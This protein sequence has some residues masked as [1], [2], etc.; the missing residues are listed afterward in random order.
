MI[1]YIKI[2]KI[3]NSYKMQ[4][5]TTIPDSTIITLLVKKSTETGETYLERKIEWQYVK[6]CETIRNQPIIDA[7]IPL[8]FDDIPDIEMTFFDIL[9]EFV[10]HYHSDTWVPIFTPPPENVE[11]KIRRQS[12]AMTQWELDKWVPMSLLELHKLTL[13]ANYLE[14]NDFVA[15]ICLEIS[16]RLEPHT[17]EQ[18]REMYPEVINYYTPAIALRTPEDL[19]LEDPTDEDSADENTVTS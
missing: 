15:S 1:F 2:Y 11:G 10:K 16:K 17:V 12:T 14:F 18:L 6:H 9:T 19:I 3:H 8:S 4:D 5:P 13:F 7:P